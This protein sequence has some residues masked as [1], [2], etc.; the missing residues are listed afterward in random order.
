MQVIP[1][2]FVMRAGPAA[3]DGRVSVRRRGKGRWRATGGVRLGGG[4]L[5]GMGGVGARMSGSSGVASTKSESAT[6][7]RL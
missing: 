3:I 2:S 7:P 6:R 5:D 4:H 1:S